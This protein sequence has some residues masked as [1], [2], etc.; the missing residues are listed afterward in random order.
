MADR[1][2]VQMGALSEGVWI[3]LHEFQHAFIDSGNVLVSKKAIT[4]PQLD[5]IN[6]H[7]ICLDK[8]QFNSDNAKDIF[9]ILHIAAGYFD[10]DDVEGVGEVFAEL[11]LKLCGDTVFVSS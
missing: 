7:I 2:L 8:S 11:T 9:N 4:Q 3:G 5:H 1:T 10:K 6:D